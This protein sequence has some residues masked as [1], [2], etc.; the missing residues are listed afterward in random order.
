MPSSEHRHESQLPQ[1][2]CQLEM[3]LVYGLA[4]ENDWVNKLWGILIPLCHKIYRPSESYLTKSIICVHTITL[5][6]LAKIRELRDW[7]MK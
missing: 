6:G 1:E 2:D 4:L 3:A 7:K 5:V